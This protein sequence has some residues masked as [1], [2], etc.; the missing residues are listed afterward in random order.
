M[1]VA[2]TSIL[3]QPM[4]RMYVVCHQNSIFVAFIHQ[5][6][7]SVKNVNSLYGVCLTFKMIRV[8]S[9]FYS[10][11][12]CACCRDTAFFY[13]MCTGRPLIKIAC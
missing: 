8:L 6:T 4:L 3:H 12:Y 9:T 5:K 10:E 2:V 13:G 7:H 1:R 11:I